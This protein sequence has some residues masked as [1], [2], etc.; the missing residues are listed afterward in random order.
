M[1]PTWLF[2]RGIAVTQPVD[3]AASPLCPM[4]YTGDKLPPAEIEE[5]IRMCDTDGDGK[6]QYENFVHMVQNAPQN[7]GLLDL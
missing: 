5:M 2:D 4:H 1:A 3:D 7:L 6:I